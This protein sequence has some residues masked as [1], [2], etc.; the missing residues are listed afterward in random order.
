MTAVLAPQPHIPNMQSEGNDIASPHPRTRR[1]NNKQNRQQ[2]QNHEALSDSNVPNAG[3]PKG[4][5]PQR[6]SQ[7]VD[8]TASAAIPNNKQAHKSQQSKSRPVSVAAPN[9]NLTATPAKASYAGAAFNASPAP[10]SLP[11]PKFFSKS[12]PGSHAASGLQARVEREGDK[13]D[14]YESVPQSTLSPGPTRSS[15]K[16]PL[17]MF[18]DAD[19]QEKART[20]SGS[21]SRPGHSSSQSRS[22]TPTK[23]RDMFMLELDGTSSPAASQSGTPSSARPQPSIERSRTAPDNVPTLQQSEDARRAQQTQSLKSFLNLT[24]AESPNNSPFLTTPQNNTFASP[25]HTPQQDPSLLYGNRNLSPLFQAARSPPAQSS[26]QYQRFNQAS[27]H[28]NNNNYANVYSSNQYLSPAKSPNPTPVHNYNMYQ[29][30]FTG[31]RPSQSPH[32][33]PQ[34]WQQPPMNGLAPQASPQQG[35]KD[36]VREMEDKM[37][38]MLKMG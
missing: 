31:S 17:D 27:P 12:V 37:R 26:P 23:P 30:D 6:N 1:Q 32:A 7:Y 13:S 16:S 34:I 20:G 29:P 15:V 35:G 5:K 11:V 19:R 9:G 8:R 2:F 18:F 3:T 24:A 14:S 22:E 4:R 21:T 10:S 36:S 33:G 38:R 25:A 28:P